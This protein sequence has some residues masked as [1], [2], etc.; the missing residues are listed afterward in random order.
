M[1]EGYPDGFKQRGID[2]GHEVFQV[3]AYALDIQ[4]RE[5]GEDGA[6]WRRWMSAFRVRARSRGYEF[7]GEGFEIG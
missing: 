3:L 6:Y 2:L 7:D 1:E 5:S 4:P